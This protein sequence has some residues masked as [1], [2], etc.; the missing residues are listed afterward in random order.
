M[1]C[2][3]CGKEYQTYSGVCPYCH[4]KNKKGNHNP[5]INYNPT[6]SKPEPIKPAPIYKPRVPVNP[7]LPPNSYRQYERTVPRCSES[8][9]TPTSRSARK[10]PDTLLL[11]FIAGCGVLILF[12]G[13]GIVG[14]STDS[15]RYFSSGASENPFVQPIITNSPRSGYSGNV[16]VQQKMPTSSRGK[17][18]IIEYHPE[19]GGTEYFKTLYIVGTAK[20]IGGR[21]ISYGSVEAKFYDKNG[22]LLNNGLDNFNDLE[23]G[24]MWKFKIVY[25]GSDV[26]EVSTYTIDVGASW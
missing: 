10:N 4:H 20:N 24:E 13:M 3:S 1:K 23:P 5:P 26:S 22:Y 18:Q 2:E 12:V 25:L 11:I 6:I 21:K 16:P 14:E 15:A 7:N 9:I 8:A 17:L 19:A